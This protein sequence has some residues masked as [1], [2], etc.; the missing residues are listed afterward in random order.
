MA[1]VILEGNE[2]GEQGFLFMFF[3]QDFALVIEER[4]KEARGGFSGRELRQAGRRTFL[5]R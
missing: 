3:L 1:L 4:G 2:L 5:A